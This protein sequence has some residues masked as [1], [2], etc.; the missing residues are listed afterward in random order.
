M[1]KQGTQKLPRTADT[2]AK[3]LYQSPHPVVTGASPEHIIAM[4]MR[5]GRDID[6]AD[7]ERVVRQSGIESASDPERIHAGVF[8]EEEIP[9]RS[10]MRLREWRKREK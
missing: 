8:P 10:K 3:V 4:K 9:E 5:A 7:I 6:W 1:N 2:R